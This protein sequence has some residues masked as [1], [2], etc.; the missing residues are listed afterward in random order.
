MRPSNRSAILDAALRVVERAGVTAVTFESVAQEAGLTKGGLVY[1]FPSRHAL[2]V[3]LQEHLAEQWE[4]A[5]VA[6]AGK[7][8]AE[9][10]ATERAAAYAR[11]A[12]TSATRAELLLVAEAATDPALAQPWVQLMESWAPPPPSGSPLSPEEADRLIAHLA[13]DG[14]WIYETLTGIA[15]PPETR[16]QLSR[17]IVEITH[18]RHEHPR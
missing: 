18:P 5:L 2:L 3:S 12:T 9:A 13:A 1:H 10:A 16:D 7:P 6:A 15:L 8:A 14:L 17:R 11:V 4:S